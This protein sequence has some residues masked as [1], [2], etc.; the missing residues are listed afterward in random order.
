MNIPEHHT[1][2]HFWHNLRSY[3]HFKA[4]CWQYA[5]TGRRAQT[6]LSISVAGIFLVPVPCS[7]QGKSWWRCSHWWVQLHVQCNTSEVSLSPL[8]I[9]SVGRTGGTQILYKKLSVALLRRGEYVHKNKF[10]V[11]R[12]ETWRSLAWDTEQGRERKRTDSHGFWINVFLL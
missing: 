6:L 7:V 9:F 11:N 10:P 2:F 1:I 12:D 3:L 5:I 4:S 8:H